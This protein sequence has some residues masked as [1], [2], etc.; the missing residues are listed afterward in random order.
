[1]E[2][3]ILDSLN[4]RIDVVDNFESF[5]W[6]E[7]HSAAG[8]FKMVVHSTL[9]NRK[10]LTAGTRLAQNGSYRVMTIQTVED[11]VDADGKTSLTIT[12]NSLED[13][14][15]A[16]VARS[17][18]SNTTTT[19]KWT[20]TGL[21]MDIAKLIYHDICT[22]GI[23]STADVIAEITEG[24]P[25]FP[26]DTI[27][28]PSTAIT[29]DLEPITVYSAIKQVCD[30]YDMGF[31]IVR[32]PVSNRLYFDIYTGSDR[33]TQQTTYSAVIFSPNLDNLQNTTE[34]RTTAGARNCAY[35][36][37][38]VGSTIVYGLDVDPTITGFDRQ[39][40][41][42]NAT[43]ITDTDST[44][45]LNKM[46]QRGKE[47]LNQARS[48]AGFDGEISQFSQ[49]KYQ[50]DYFLGDLVEMQNVD[51]VVN[52]MQVTEVIFVSDSEGERIY[53]TLS[54]NEF[55]TPGSWGAWDFNQHWADVLDT[56]HWADLP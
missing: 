44:V 12:G 21:P 49:Y 27:A 18:L 50:T 38:P 2:A 41:L 25:L 35:V 42:V 10:R 16:R 11:S 53:P 48:F 22:I 37:S 7:R 34:V 14:L 30:L 20:I 32:D 17:A 15:N 33:T 3:Y 52:Q 36:V 40:L 5:L 46:I 8:D 29:V 6:T 26:V 24:S 47:A 54:T 28:A 39:V 9:Q 4:R 55:I 45:A 13:I 31:R 1:V 43:D 56:L 19:P 51:G 23:L